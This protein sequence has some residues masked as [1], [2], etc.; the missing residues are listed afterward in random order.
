MP[1]FR[2]LV[3]R[4]AKNLILMPRSGPPTD[5]AKTLWEELALG[6]VCVE[7][8]ACGVT[9]ADSLKAVLDEYAASMPRISGCFQSTM[10]LRDAVFQNMSYE[11]WKT[12][13]DPKVRGSWNL[14]TLLPNKG[15]DFFVFLSSISG[16]IGLGGQ[17]NYAAGNTYMDALARYCI[18]QGEKGSSLDLGAITDKGLLAENEVLSNRVLAGGNLLPVSSKEL[19][20]ILDFHCNPEVVLTARNCQTLIGIETLANVKA[21]R[22]EQANWVTTPSFRHMHQIDSTAGA[23]VAD[24]EEAVDFR[25]MFAEASSLSEAGAVVSLALLKKLTRTLSTLQ[26]DEVDMRKSLHTY[27]VDSLLAVEL[28]SW[29]AREFSADIPIFEI[30][31]ASSFSSVGISVARKS[32]YYQATWI[33]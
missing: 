11:D 28:R 12:C 21:K 6:G 26:V 25:K 15:M 17:A 18:S 30:S 33:E 24:T 27:G 29:F 8:P 20:A 31:G 3:S 10:I 23:S 13:L 5:A 22:L 1:M 14:H 16:I 2:W 32:R 9:D 7:V 4:G 19:F